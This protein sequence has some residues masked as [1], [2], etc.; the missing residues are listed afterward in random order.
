MQRSMDGPEWLKQ[1]AAL[2][3]RGHGVQIAA[4]WMEDG[5]PLHLCFRPFNCGSN[6]EDALPLARLP[7]AVW[8][9]AGISPRRREWL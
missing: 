9:S 6:D 1:V 7:L 5:V 8:L 2:W 3:R 4:G